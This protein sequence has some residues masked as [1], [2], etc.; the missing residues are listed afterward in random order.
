M[1]NVLQIDSE[2]G[3]I[4]TKKDLASL[5]YRKHVDL[6]VIAQDNGVPSA[7]TLSG[8]T[9]VWLTFDRFEVVETEVEHSTVA[10]TKTGFYNVDVPCDI[11]TDTSVFNLQDAV[12]SKYWF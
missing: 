7:P 3:W 12:K 5:A 2:T 10:S 11:Q 6:P 1:Y 4:S 9:T 8:K